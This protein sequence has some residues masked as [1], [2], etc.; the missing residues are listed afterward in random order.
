M[1][2]SSAATVISPICAWY[3][4]TCESKTHTTHLLSR[5]KTVTP[6]RKLKRA[7]RTEC[8]L[9]GIVLASIYSVSYLNYL[10]FCVRI[11]RMS[12]RRLEFAAVSM[13][14]HLVRT[15]TLLHALTKF[16]KIGAWSVLWIM[17]TISGTPF[18][19]GNPTLSRRFC[20]FP[21][22]EKVQMRS[23]SGNRRSDRLEWATKFHDG[24]DGLIHQLEFI[25]WNLT[26]KRLEGSF[27][28]STF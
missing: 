20:C 3:W 6:L 4:R 28:W 10:G 12:Q 7:S 23:Q 8:C 26:Q 25:P 21:M 9:T 18:F 19:R 13:I 24:R 11:S 14:S 1:K 5:S 16:E 22:L 17:E 27:L 2:G 15:L